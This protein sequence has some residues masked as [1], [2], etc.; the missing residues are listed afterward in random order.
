MV[1]GRPLLTEEQIRGRVKELADKINSDYKGKEILAIGILKGAFMFFSDLVKQINVPLTVDFIVSSSYE[2]TTTTG[3]VNI[4]FDT[5]KPVTG[6]DVLI[7]ED[8]IDTGISLNYIKERLLLKSP[9][10]LKICVFMD[11]KER[12]LVDVE[13]DYTGFEIPDVFVVGYGTD[14]NDNFRNLPYVANLDK[15]KEVLK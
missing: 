7:I 3:K 13:V 4:H 15:P 8:I 14:Y 2:D 11:K 6:K 12:R 9:N 1:I 5:R 10:T